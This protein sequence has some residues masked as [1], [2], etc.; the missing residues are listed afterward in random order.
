MS[1]DL[2][3]R[4]P[5]LI[6]TGGFGYIISCKGD[7]KKKIKY[8]VKLPKDPYSECNLKDELDN[9]KYINSTT[10]TKPIF[11]DTKFGSENIIKYYDATTINGLNGINVH[12]IYENTEGSNNT[13]RQNAVKEIQQRINEAIRTNCFVAIEYCDRGDL[14]EF[15]ANHPEYISQSSFYKDMV[16]QIFSSL[17]YLYNKK[18]CHWDIKPENIFVKRNPKYGVNNDNRK[19]LF[20][21]A[22]YGSVMITPTVEIIS[23]LGVS[24]KLMTKTEALEFIKTNMDKISFEGKPVDIDP[25][26][27]VINNNPQTYELKHTTEDICYEFQTT[28][29]YTPPTPLTLTTFYRDIYAFVL[30][31]FNIFLKDDNPTKTALKNTQDK[32]NNDERLPMRDLAS[33]K[34]EHNYIFQNKNSKIAKLLWNIARVVKDCEE[35]IITQSEY[36]Y[37][38]KQPDNSIVEHPTYYIPKKIIIDVPNEI[39]KELYEGIGELFETR[40]GKTLKKIHQRK[41]AAQTQKNRGQSTLG[42]QA[43]SNDNFEAIFE[44]PENIEEDLLGKHIV[45]VN[46]SI[47][48]PSTRRNWTSGH[49]RS[50]LAWN[51][52]LTGLDQQRRG[53]QKTPNI[54]RRTSFRSHA[55]PAY[56]QTLRGSRNNQTTPEYLKETN[57]G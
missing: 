34:R 30:T 31:I 35:K 2:S 42:S 44:V 26:D 11:F 20:K 38:I 33:K 53:F 49:N 39:Y 45:F 1:S 21:I 19:Y 13:I 48:P 14:K 55:A 23:R 54:L 15:I 25:I 32:K 7:D 57:F 47:M 24:K 56:L 29:F 37:Y 16:Y 51:N 27:L 18:V 4:D 36:L 3:C 46:S 28:P 5:N 9:S 10:F 43:S 6:G 52:T 41:I 22:D 40:I 8:V 17:V 12:N 50:G